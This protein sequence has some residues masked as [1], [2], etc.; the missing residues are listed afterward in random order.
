MILKAWGE[1]NAAGGLASLAVRRLSPIAQA[2]SATLSVTEAI[3]STILFSEERLAASASIGPAFALIESDPSLL[4][5]AKQ[6][7]WAVVDIGFLVIE[8]APFVAAA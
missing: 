2:S 1:M 4:S 5:L 6:W 8:L 3:S 7:G